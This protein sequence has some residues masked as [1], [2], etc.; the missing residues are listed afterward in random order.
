MRRRWRCRLLGAIIIL[1]SPYALPADD[2]KDS[3]DSEDFQTWTI[4]G[5][6]LTS[7]GDP[8]EGVAVQLDS[9]L[10]AE[11]PITMETNLQGEYGTEI[12]GFSD[13]SV[14]LRG[15]LIAKKAGYMEGRE[16]LELGEGENSATIDIILR[17]PD[18]DPDLLPMESLIRLLAPPL[19]ADAVRKY[20]E[21]GASKE[22]LRGCAELIN[23]RSAVDAVSPLQT[24]VDRTPECLE[25]RLLLS[26][27]LLDSGSWTGA[28]NQLVEAM[29]A[30]N[31]GSSPR[32]EPDCIM[33][34]L[35]SWRGHVKDA[36][37][38]Y[39]HAL[40]FD[41]DNALVLQ[42]LGR[43]LVKQSNWE[44]AEHY[45]AEAIKAGAGNTARILR[46]GAL[47]EIGDAG[48]ANREMERYAAGRKIKDL[49][50]QARILHSKIHSR[51]NLIKQEQVQSMIS[52][53]PEELKR[54]IPELEGLEA[55]SGQDMLAPV[56]ERTGQCV[57]AFFKTITNTASLEEV[58]QERLGKEGKVKDSLD[59]Q[60]EYIMLAD[61]SESRLGIKEYRSTEDGSDAAM[62]GLR[63]GFM[64]TSGFASVPSIFH[65]LNRQGADFRYLG[66]Q[67]LNGREAHVIAFA[68]KP[69]TAK[70]MTR[71]STD[72]GRALILVHGLAWVDAED[73]HV[74]R[75]HTYLLN[76]VPEVRLQ[77]LAT[78]IQFHRV[79]FS[80]LDGG[81]WLPEQVEI[82]VDWRGRHLRNQHRY[83]DFRLFN[84]ETIDK[85]QT[86]SAG[87]SPSP[88]AR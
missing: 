77:K 9:E 17:T 79:E 51:L 60:F 7:E 55:A 41:P 76:P 78:E 15:T 57:E 46:A 52:Q 23:K 28:N 30:N 38:S 58:H 47:L 87:T 81:L 14:R 21:E 36:V 62:D 69:E 85:V 33:G 68:Q 34:V 64:L 42:E 25:C 37:A 65:P 10:S 22:F 66:K 53:S 50:L 54:I 29:E 24:S 2:S 39:L 74:L 32:P 73:F 49:P 19:K 71:F 26:L 61:Y 82:T 84:I 3:E 18:E 56:L 6:V 43:M 59:Q 80:G 35:R 5:R 40:E 20:P 4:S 1:L 44:A 88:A 8:L 16:L 83:S 75:L 86:P 11:G 31:S 63:K 13:T 27:A 45:L 72:E 48:E 70:V 12:S 67:M